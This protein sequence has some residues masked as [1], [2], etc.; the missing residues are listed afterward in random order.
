L[1]VALS[2]DDVYSVPGAFELPI[3]ASAAATCG[4]YDGVVCLGAVIRGETPHFDFVCDR[5][6]AGI[7]RVS[8]DTGIPVSFSVLTTDNI[9]QAMARAGG[10]VGNKGYEGVVGMVR[11]IDELRRIREGG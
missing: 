4:R 5:A 6:A 3:A 1:G 8:L 11:T 7:L 10:D 2:D 9:E